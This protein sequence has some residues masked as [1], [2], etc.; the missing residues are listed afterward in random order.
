MFV[1]L[2]AMLVPFKKSLTKR[3]KAGYTNIDGYKVPTENAETAF[4][5]VLVPLSTDDL[6]PRREGLAELGNAQ[7]FVSDDED[8]DVN[9]IVIDENGIEFK[10][11]ELINYNTD[12]KVKEY[13]VQ[14]LT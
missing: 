3:T 9:D 7:L 13:I 11:M 12:L 4:N 8:I 5:G 10:V 6:D 1:D 14:R 2:R